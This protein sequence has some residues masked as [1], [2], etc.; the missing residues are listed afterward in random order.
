MLAP[1]TYQIQMTN[2]RFNFRRSETVTVAPGEVTAHTVSLPT[3]ALRISV[4]D[5]TEVTVDGQP[6][7]RAPFAE[8]LPLVVGTHEIKGSHPEL[9]ERRAA[10]DVKFQ[11]TTDATLGFRP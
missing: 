11:E 7:G 5:G 3:G 4:P 2:A 9:G 1:G 6:I 10:I 8:L